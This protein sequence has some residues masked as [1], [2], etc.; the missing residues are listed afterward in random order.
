MHPYDDNYIQFMEDTGA[1]Y[2][3]RV[4]Q[5]IYFR[6][7]SELG[8]FDIFSD[9]DSKLAHLNRIYKTIL[10]IGMMNL[11]IGVMNSLVGVYYSGNSLIGMFNLLVTALVMYGVG[12]IQGKIEY[13]E[14]ERKLRE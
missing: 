12:R 3:G 11:I 6:K 9:I 5:W 14:K 10:A 13:L 1:E 8:R 2:V 7:K 4:L